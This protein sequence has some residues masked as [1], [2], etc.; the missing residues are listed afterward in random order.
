[1]AIT[2]TV[3]NKLKYELGLGTVNFS[4]HVFKAMLLDTSFVYNQDTHGYVSDVVSDEITSAGG[5]ARVTLTVDVAWNQ[6]DTDNK[7]AVAWDNITFTA[8]GASFDDFVA[9][10]IY[11]DSHASDLIIGCI[12][13]G[14]TLS[15]GDGNS[16]QLQ[17]IGFELADPA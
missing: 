10:V 3:S 6:N 16:F 12:A 1:M 17:N 8:S 7:G 11:D 2:R 14:Q 5:Y 4:S 15:V 9:V 13:L